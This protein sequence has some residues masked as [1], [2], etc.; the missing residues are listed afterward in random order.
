MTH[1]TVSRR[2]VLA[3]TGSTAL[4]LALSRHAAATLPGSRPLA[5]LD[6]LLTTDEQTAARQILAALETRVLEPDLV[7]EWRRGLQGAIEKAGAIAVTRWDKAILLRQLAR[8]HGLQ[9]RQTRIEHSL[10]VTELTVR[11]A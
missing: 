7:W 4:A 8:E 5:L 2:T 6:G 9:V 11:P 1:S 3:G 10:F